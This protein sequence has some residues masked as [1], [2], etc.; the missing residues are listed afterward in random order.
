MVFNGEQIED[1]ET[2]TQQYEAELQELV[3]MQYEIT[4]GD[5]VKSSCQ[6]IVQHA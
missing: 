2:R 3:K 6:E 5:P 4:G 1:I